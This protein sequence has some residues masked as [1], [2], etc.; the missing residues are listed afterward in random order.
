VHIL[1]WERDY[2]NGLWAA[3]SFYAGAK[4]N[5]PLYWHQG[6]FLSVKAKRQLKTHFPDSLLLEAD[7]ADREVARLLDTRGLIR[8]RAARDKAFMLRK[9]IDPV[10]LGRTD[11]MLLLDTDVLFFRS[12]E[13]I[14]TA[15]ASGTTVSHF[16]RDVGYWY[17]ITPEAAKQRHG[18]DLVPD[19]NAGLGL[20]PRANV[21][22]DLIEQF[23]VDPDLLTE[24]WLTEQTLQALLA[25]RYGVCH[26]PD[27]YNLSTSPG[28]ATSDGR[29]FVAKHY[30]GHPR[31]WLY[32]EGMPHLLRLGLLEFGR[33]RH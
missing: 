6:G 30:P 7:T 9:L 2:L 33:C 22:L 1:V 13:E 12:P 21:D 19:L 15:V 17:N 32:Q 29:P 3:K 23:L 24:P 25:S 26:L 4:V 10:L 8:C 11:Y 20:V 14:L 28:L 31:P 5:W 27:T 18:I 16:N